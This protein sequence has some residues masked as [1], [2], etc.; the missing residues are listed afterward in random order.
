MATIYR[1]IPGLGTGRGGL[2]VAAR[3]RLYTAADHLLVLQSTGYTEEYKRIFFR[4]IRCIDVHK[5]TMQQW[6]GVIS[7]VLTLLIFLLYF[8]NVPGGLVAVFCFP[9]VIWFTVNLRRGPTCECYISTHVQTLKLPTPR[10]E[11]KVATLIAFLR[12]QAAAFAPADAPQ[13]VS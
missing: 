12:T 9:F 1:K 2:Q 4:D 13:P 10:R 7:G 3:S 11:K 8:I 5:T 6:S